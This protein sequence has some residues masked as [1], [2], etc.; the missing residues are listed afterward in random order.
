MRASVEGNRVIVASAGTL[1]DE[2]TLRINAQNLEPKLAQFGIDV[3]AALD[4]FKLVRKGF[5]GV[6]TLRDKND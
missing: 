3:E 2:Q 6:E 5:E 1:P 4:R